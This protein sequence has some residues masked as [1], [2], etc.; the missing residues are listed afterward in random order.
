M[1]K[2]DIKVGS[3][4]ENIAGEIAYV[5]KILKDKIRVCTNGKR[6][7]ILNDSLC[8]WELMNPIRNN[9]IVNDITFAVRLNQFLKWIPKNWWMSQPHYYEE[10]EY[11]KYVAE[12]LLRHQIKTVENEHE[13]NY[14]KN[15]NLI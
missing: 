1:N 15:L 3:R 8:H 2:E 14:F 11:I 13:L 10:Y 9:R 5:D 7:Y 6:E 4:I 12:E